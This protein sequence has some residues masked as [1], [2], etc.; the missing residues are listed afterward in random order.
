MAEGIYARKWEAGT[1]GLAALDV[2]TQL[3]I[4]EQTVDEI[5]ELAK[6]Y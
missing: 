4:T 5:T 6:G 1:K 3:D 2:W